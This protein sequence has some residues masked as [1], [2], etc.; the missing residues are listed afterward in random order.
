MPSVPDLCPALSAGSMSIFPRNLSSF[1]HCMNSCNQFQIVPPFSSLPIKNLKNQGLLSFLSCYCPCLR[2]ALVTGILPA[3]TAFIGPALLTT[4]TS[5]ST[6]VWVAGLLLTRTK[7]A[8]PHC[9]ELSAPGS[10][11]SSPTWFSKL[12]SPRD[13]RMEAA[14]PGAVFCHQRISRAL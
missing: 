9:H 1:A 10:I 4:S 12:I 14:R 5:A 2:E 6:P 7:S 8:S 13:G 3:W 11:P